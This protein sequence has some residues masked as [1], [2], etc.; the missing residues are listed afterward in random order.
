VYFRGTELLKLVA[1]IPAPP[2]EL[3]QL[4]RPMVASE[5]V[6]RLGVAAAAAA[7]VTAL[8]LRRP[9]PWFLARWMAPEVRR[10]ASDLAFRR[11]ELLLRPGRQPLTLCLIR[12]GQSQANT[13]QDRIVGGRDAASP[14][15]S[16]GEA[17]AVAVGSRLAALGLRF[18]RVYASHAVRARRTA[19]LACSEL[20]L[21]IEAVRVEPRVVEFSQGSLELRPREEVYE[22]GGPVLRGIRRERMFYRPP[23]LSPD[24][25]R[26]ESQ[27]DVELRVRAFVTELQVGLQIDGWMDRWIDRYHAL[28]HSHA[29][30]SCDAGPIHPS[31]HLSI[32]SF[33]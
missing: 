17:Q 15:T 11:Q 22:E 3:P 21:P 16:K 12:H 29:T 28:Y 18:D 19:E 26:G 8:W 30:R 32:Y 6:A 7:V 10:A 23:G 2:P 9:P 1:C 33:I 13:A 5:L 24:G 4:A 25:D 27:H 20:G 14:L 31:I